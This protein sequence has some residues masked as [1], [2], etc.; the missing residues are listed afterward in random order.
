[1]CSVI[2]RSGSDEES[3]FATGEKKQILRV[4]QDDNRLS[5]SCRG[6]GAVFADCTPACFNNSS[7]RAR[8]ASS[9]LQRACVGEWWTYF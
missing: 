5:A 9:S 8:T 6:N 1:M 2:L 3:A 7:I 4:A